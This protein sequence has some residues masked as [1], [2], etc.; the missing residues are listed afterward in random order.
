[1]K[2]YLHILNVIVATLVLTQSMTGVVTFTDITIFSILKSMPNPDPIE[3]QI[4][5]NSIWSWSQLVPMKNILLFVDHETSCSFLKTEYPNITCYNFASLKCLHSTYKRPYIN[6]AFDIAQQQKQTSILVFVNGDIMLHNS[7]SHTISFVNANMHEFFLVGCRRDYEMSPSL[8]YSDSEK[9]LQ[10]GL[11]H[12]QIHSTTGIDFIAFKINTS[13]RMPPF[14]VGVYRWDNWLLS[15]ILLRTN[16]TVIDV[17]QSI[18]VIHQQR[19]NLEGEKPEPHSLRRGAVYNDVLVKNISGED[20][21]VGFINNANQIL[22][23]NCAQSQCTFKDNLDRSEIV[24]LKQR[25]NAQKYI[26][27]LTVTSGYMPLAWNWICW[28]KRIEFRNYILL[29]EDLEAYKI[30]RAANE[31]VFISKEQSLNTSSKSEAK[32][33]S[34]AFQITMMYRLEFLMRVLRAGFHFL[35]ADMDTLWLSNPFNYIS[36]DLSI[37]IQGQTHKQTKMSGGFIIIHAT[38]KGRKLWQDV[39]KCQ[40]QNL[41]DLREQQHLK[42]KRPTSDFT[43]QECIN[44]RLNTTKMNLLDPYLFP[45]GRSF[46]D[47]HRPQSRGIVPVVIHG[48]WLVGLEAKIKRLRSWNLLASTGSS[49]DPLENG[50]PYSLSKRSN[51]VRIRIRILTYNRL[52]SLQRLFESLQAANYLNDSVALDISVDRPSSEAGSSEKE[53]WKQVMEYVGDGET[54]PSKFKWS[55]GPLSIIVHKKHV[56]LPGQWTVSTDHQDVQLFLEDD[57]VVSPHF[58]IFL[59]QAIDFYYINESNYDS[60]MFGLSMQHQHTVLGQRTGFSIRSIDKELNETGAPTFFKYQLLGTWGAVFFPEHWRAFLEWITTIKIENIEEGC[61]P[62]GLLSTQWWVSRHLAGRMWTHWF[63]RF[64]YERGWYSLYTNF[65]NR[66]ALIVCY[67]ESGLNFNVTRGPMNPIVKHLQ[68]N[69]HLN[70]TKHLPVFDY[71]FSLIDQPALL[72][73]R[74]NLWHRHYFINQCR[75]I[76]ENH[77]VSP[78]LVKLKNQPLVKPKSNTPTHIKGVENKTRITRSIQTQLLEEV[79]LSP[80]SDCFKWFLLFELIFVFPIVLL[81][82][83]GACLISRKKHASR[84]KP[85]KR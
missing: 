52:Q 35:S 38:S 81:I 44:N 23:G 12:S 53:Q 54:H 69:V 57:V 17:T 4:Q 7:I 76:E 63:I 56:G 59:K 62:G 79:S 46:F 32:Y 36:H 2:I 10:N 60:R 45:D 37:T 72:S 15:E 51:P 80:S 25:A 13:V 21:K 29:A 78:K 66:E 50:I 31:P 48:N 27:V 16:I 58:Y 84:R 26:A 70:F 75:I 18:F 24:L 85:F 19:K 39:I 49:C 30:L 82:V 55:H 1:M 43:E 83:L 28:S 33:G 47:L 20:Y 34:Y 77:K 67:R 73:M 5:T 40:N 11:N 71:H 64:V 41:V 8:N 61:T 65:P 22:S 74:H 9:T 3:H 6:C 42:R 68:S 14:L